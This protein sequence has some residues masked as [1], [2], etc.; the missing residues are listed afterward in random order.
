MRSYS[1]RINDRTLGTLEGAILAS[2]RMDAVEKLRAFGYRFEDIMLTDPEAPHETVSTA[3]PKED[4]A[5]DSSIK[6]ALDS[7]KQADALTS[8]LQEMLQEKERGGSEIPRPP[9]RG[10]IEPRRAPSPSR[11][12]QVAEKAPGPKPT[13]PQSPREKEIPSPGLHRL[14][15]GSVV[16]FA[17][18]TVTLAILARGLTASEKP[19]NKQTLYQRSEIRITGSIEPGSPSNL[20]LLLH[21]PELPL[22]LEIPA[23]DLSRKDGD[24]EIRRIFYSKRKPTFVLAG[25]SVPGTGE[26]TLGRHEIIGTPRECRLPPLSP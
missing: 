13:Y 5:F 18:L 8:L 19:A 25:V 26:R 14:T 21:F 22:D 3:A 6:K 12:P 10:E 23:R 20:T 17:I 9:W 1:Y 24:F 11:E 2:N 7:A 16:V 4:A 15:P